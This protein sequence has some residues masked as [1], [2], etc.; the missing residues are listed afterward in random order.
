LKKIRA[1]DCFPVL[2]GDTLKEEVK[3]GSFARDIWGAR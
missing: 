1:E 2:P 3:L